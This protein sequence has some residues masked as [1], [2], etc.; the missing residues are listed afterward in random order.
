MVCV[1]WDR[2][3]CVYLCRLW[4][5]PSTW[6][7]TVLLSNFRSP[8][9]IIALWTKQVKEDSKHWMPRLVDLHVHTSCESLLLCARLFYIY[10]LGRRLRVP[11]LRKALSSYVLAGV[12]DSSMEVWDKL[13]DGAFVLYSAWHALSYFNLITLAER[14]GHTVRINRNNTC[15]QAL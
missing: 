8:E 2:V 4:T 11:K 14:D 5:P 6:A 3:L 10:P 13:M 7:D 15:T 1:L 12:L 9:Y